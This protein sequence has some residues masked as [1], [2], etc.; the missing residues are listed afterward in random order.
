MPTERFSPPPEESS[1]EVPQIPS[2]AT[3]TGREIGE[4]PL[5][6]ELGLPRQP[7]ESEE[8]YQERLGEEREEE[9]RRFLMQLLAQHSDNGGEQGQPL[10]Q[11]ILRQWLEPELARIEERLGPERQEQ[12]GQ[13]RLFL[14]RTRLMETLRQLLCRETSLIGEHLEQLEPD[15]LVRQLRQLRQELVPVLTQLEPDL[16]TTVGLKLIPNPGSFPIDLR[17]QLHQIINHLAEQQPHDP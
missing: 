2:Q 13:R 17:P 7:G 10:V 6:L 15:Q 1:P 16:R 5:V 8:A 3:Y 4:Q 14:A 9:L 12:L 11:D